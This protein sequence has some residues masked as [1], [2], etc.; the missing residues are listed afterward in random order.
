[1]TRP[2][3]CSR[4]LITTGLPDTTC[5]DTQHAPGRVQLGPVSPRGKPRRKSR[6]P[7][8]RCA[9]GS[10]STS[11]GSPPTPTRRRW[12]RGSRSSR[13]IPRPSGAPPRRCCSAGLTATTMMRNASIV[14]HSEA[15]APDHQAP[16]S[17]PAHVCDHCNVCNAAPTASLDSIPAGQF[18][19]ARLLQIFLPS[20]TTVRGHL[21]T[22][23]HLAR[24]PPAFA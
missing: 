4:T 5:S 21:A 19:P 23:P 17:A 12:S 3:A 1:M 2:G 15:A 9:T 22:T 8:T 7:W 11:G 20:S 13:R 14:R 16:A 6:A 10:R 24:G 18:A